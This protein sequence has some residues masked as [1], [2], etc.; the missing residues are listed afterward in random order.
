MDGD[1]EMNT[2]DDAQMGS[3]VFTPPDGCWVPD[4]QGYIAG[5]ASDLERKL[6]LAGIKLRRELL[7]NAH[8]DIEAWSL[9]YNPPSIHEASH[10]LVEMLL[11]IPEEDREHFA[12]LGETSVCMPLRVME[13]YLYPTMKLMHHLQEKDGKDL[14]GGIQTMA[15]YSFFLQ[16][17]LYPK[18][19]AQEDL[20]VLK[21]AT[22]TADHDLCSQVRSEVQQVDTAHIQMRNALYNLQKALT[23]P[24]YDDLMLKGPHFL[25][26]RQEEIDKLI[27]LYDIQHQADFTVAKFNASKLTMLAHLAQRQAMEALDLNIRLVEAYEQIDSKIEENTVNQV[28][29]SQH[30]MRV[31][32]EQLLHANALQVG[33][34]LRTVQ[35]KINPYDVD[36][37][38]RVL[39]AQ[40]ETFQDLTNKNAVLVT[41][42]SELRMHLSFMP[43]QHR[44][45]VANLQATCDPLYTAQ[46]RDPKVIIPRDDHMAGGN[47]VLTHAPM[48]H[49]AVQECLRDAKYTSFQHAKAVLDKGFQL[50]ARIC[51]DK[52]TA[53][54]A[55]KD[56][57]LTQYTY[58]TSKLGAPDPMQPITTTDASTSSSVDMEQPP[59]LA[60]DQYAK[61]KRPMEGGGRGQVLKVPRVEA[62]TDRSKGKSKPSSSF[63]PRFREYY[64]P[65]V[66]PGEAQYLYELHE[67]K[68]LPKKNVQLTPEKLETLLGAVPTEEDTSRSPQILEAIRNTE[69]NAQLYVYEMHQER[70]R[71]GTHQSY[72]VD[73]NGFTVKPEQVNSAYLYTLLPYKDTHKYG[74]YWAIL[75]KRPGAAA[76]TVPEYMPNKQHRYKEVLRD[77]ERAGLTLSPSRHW[78]EVPLSQFK[79]EFLYPYFPYLM[80]NKVDIKRMNKD[81]NL[82]Q[83]PYKSEQVLEERTRVDKYGVTR[84][85]G[86]DVNPAATMAM[87]L[88]LQ[89]LPDDHKSTLDAYLHKLE[90]HMETLKDTLSRIPF[91]ITHKVATAQL[92]R[93]SG[94]SKTI[95][96]ITA[97]KLVYGR[98]VNSAPAAIN[99][100]P[101]K[102]VPFDGQ[103]PVSDPWNDPPSPA[104][105]QE[106]DDD[107]DRQDP[108]GLGGNF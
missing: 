90:G 92:H 73:Y 66:N 59:P 79:V 68:R 29:H 60:H 103:S 15:M 13:K 5:S 26:E 46:R 33:S 65:I 93:L 1:N 34:A 56:S 38:R 81:L 14:P 42:N 10:S 83:I 67:A 24:E 106:N 58:L 7:M 102:G 28:M 44:D 37:M 101:N 95:R 18:K 84:S 39:M 3:E 64:Y 2:V 91:V 78:T 85:T 47:I 105:E 57:A 51:T 32:V 100:D 25:H 88:S 62:G 27:A 54:I 21:A 45:F 71:D 52:G 35:D 53:R 12:P 19:R 9:L 23:L 40:K 76:L 50:R 86:K 75:R 94:L 80:G 6:K 20:D 70:R 107:Q 96:H 77:F 61:G 89:I 74:D 11:N 4:T 104:K 99:E 22:L 69:L 97:P 98:V 72:Y 16:G 87:L 108:S 30:A 8:N 48:S 43:V 55:F 82:H 17:Q 49:P 41:E 31:Q 63:F 36:D